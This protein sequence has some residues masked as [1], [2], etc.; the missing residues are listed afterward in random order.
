[1]VQLTLYNFMH[2]GILKGTP[3]LKLVVDGWPTGS[4][5]KAEDGSTVIKPWDAPTWTSSD[6][7]AKTE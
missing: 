4:R 3:D 7:P 2:G 6:H 1:M 5:E